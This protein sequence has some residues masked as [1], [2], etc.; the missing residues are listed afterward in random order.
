MSRRAWRIVGVVVAGLAAAGAAIVTN[1]LTE[2]WSSALWIGL[3]VLVTVGLAGQ[4]LALWPAEQ[5]GPA[6]VHGGGPGSVV[7]G[8]D[9]HAPITVRLDGTHRDR[10]PPPPSS[11]GTGDADAPS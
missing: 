5:E 6:G 11:D 3:G 8:R 10:L 4:L 1:A 9:N 7:V 2:R